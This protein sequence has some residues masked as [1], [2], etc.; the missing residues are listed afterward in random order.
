MLVF[1]HQSA[2]IS[3][4]LP[5]INRYRPIPLVSFQVLMDLG[6]YHCLAI[7][8]CGCPVRLTL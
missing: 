6:E 8:E 5:E 7:G 4:R 1:V 2:C 3:N